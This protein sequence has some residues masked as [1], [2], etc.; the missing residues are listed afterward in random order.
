MRKTLTFSLSPALLAL[1]CFA[2]RNA[3]AQDPP[4]EPLPPLPATEAAPSSPSPSAAAQSDTSVRTAGAVRANHVDT[5]VVAEPG[6]Q[7]T[8]HHDSSSEHHEYA[9]DPGRK[10]AMIASPIVFGVGAA[11]AGIAYLTARGQTNCNY[12]TVQ[13]NNGSF[14]QTVNC[15]SGDTAPPLV[16][17]DVIVGAVPSAPRWVVGD[18]GGALLYTGLRGSSLIVASVVDWG[19]GSNNWVGP[20]MLGFLVP[21]TL[22]IVD[23]A[24][25]PHRE[26]LAPAK[27]S[28]E[29]GR[30]IRPRI[31]GVTPVALTDAEHRVNGGALTMSASF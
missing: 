19:N 23:L 27:P 7:V 14:N 5:V 30:V 6:S 9:P 25:T 21:I 24:T 2:P 11:V 31:T 13:T 12:A 17:Y 4:S 15:T 18:V 28:T 10:A 1:L 8:V 3:F 16:M 20:F 29:E 22:G 26:D